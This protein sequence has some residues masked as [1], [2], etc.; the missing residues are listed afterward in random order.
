MFVRAFTAHRRCGPTEFA[1]SHAYVAA[2]ARSVSSAARVTCTGVVAAFLIPS[3][4]GHEHLPIAAELGAAAP[5][6]DPAYATEG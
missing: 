5:L 3:D 6:P 2:L 1:T 4:G